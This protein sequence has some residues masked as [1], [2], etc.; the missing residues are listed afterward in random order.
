M[1]W[2]ISVVVWVKH[3][4]HA[5]SQA[6]LKRILE[7]EWHGTPQFPI[8][9]DCLS[10][11]TLFINLRRT[12]PELLWIP[13]DMI[14]LRQDFESFG[15]T[16]SRHHSDKGCPDKYIANICLNNLRSVFRN[17]TQETQA[18]GDDKA[19]VRGS[20]V[21]G[22]LPKYAS[23]YWMKHYYRAHPNLVFEYASFRLLLGENQNID[24]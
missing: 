23:R 21:N 22:V 8:E 19:G 6:E 1:P 12:L 9:E 4:I 3:A 10:G 2:V 11:E 5:L 20:I 16:W 14:T 13:G 17:S 7:I 15:Q 24:L 18:T